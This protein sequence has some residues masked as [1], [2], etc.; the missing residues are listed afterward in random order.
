MARVV[1]RRY[2]LG[3]FSVC[4]VLF[5]RRS[6]FNRCVDRPSSSNVNGSEAAR[7]E[8]AAAEAD[9]DNERCYRDVLMASHSTRAY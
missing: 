4:V 7:E 9:V 6:V 3:I 2:P 1:K 8:E 5:R